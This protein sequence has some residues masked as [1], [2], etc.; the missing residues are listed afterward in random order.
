MKNHS[1]D[2]IFSEKKRVTIKDIADIAGVSVA[3]VSLALNNCKSISKNTSFKIHAIAEKLNYTPS[4]LARGLVKK[5]TNTIGLIVSDITDPFYADLARGVEDK[6][7]ENG[8]CVMLCNSDNQPDKEKTYINLLTEQH[9]AVLIIVPVENDVK[10]VSIASKANIPVIFADRKI[11]DST[12]SSVSANNHK[13]AYEGIHHLIQLKHTKIACIASISF[14]F[15]TISERLRGYKA[16]LSD[17]SISYDER[18]ISLSNGRIDG[19]ITSTYS[20]LKLLPKPTAIF[21][22]SDVV[23]FGVIEALMKEGYKIPEDISVLGFD[24]IYY[25]E[26]FR[27]PLTTVH[28]PKYE[29][30]EIIFNLCLEKIKNKKDIYKEIVLDTRLIIR[31][32]SGACSNE[33]SA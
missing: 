9:I 17:N 26:F 3:T 33:L 12:I 16:V 10:S 21:A 6:A 19:G 2:I 22:M 13:G 20:L 30:G 31:E 11:S 7:F 24:N 32:S 4:A 18:Y 27:V 23:A 14:N 5:K 8:Y 1:N 15:S 29:M 25:S 28:Q